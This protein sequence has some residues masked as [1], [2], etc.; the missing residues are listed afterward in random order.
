[1][2]AL[3]GFLLVTGRTALISGTGLR[4][5]LAAFIV[6]VVGFLIARALVGFLEVRSRHRWTM[7][8]HP[9]A[10]FITAGSVLMIVAAGG[11]IW[12]YANRPSLHGDWSLGIYIS[13]TEE[14]IDFAPFG[15]QPVLAADH[16]TDLPCAFLADPVLINDDGEF[17]LF[18]EAWNRLTDEGDICLSS[19]PDGR[20]WT[21]R[22]RV[23]DESCSLSYPTVFEHEGIWYMI[24]ES[25]TLKEIRLYRAEEF[26]ERW[27]FDRMLLEGSLYRDTNIIEYEDH[28]YL[29][30]LPDFGRKLEIYHADSPLGPWLAHENNPVLSDDYDH[31]RGGGSIVYQSGRLIRFVQDIR[32]YY[33]NRLRAVEIKELTPTS[34]VQQPIRSEPILVGHDNWNTMGMHTLSCVQLEDGRWLAAVD[35]HGQIFD[36]KAASRFW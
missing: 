31:L 32:P 26:P 7:S 1:M 18:Y 21:Y 27:V 29:L 28:W 11:L 13:A 5:L 9:L 17:L 20:E 35:G 34:Y 30:T 25:R 16:V 23:L 15:D 14:P 12:H 10:W 33:G 36:T 8:A 6:L 24:P 4:K 3:A 2:T 22:G 19:S